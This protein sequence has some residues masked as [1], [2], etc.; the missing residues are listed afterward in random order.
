M[1]VNVPANL[2][3]VGELRKENIFVIDQQRATSQDIRPSED[4]NTQSNAP[5]ALD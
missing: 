2:P 3:A 5:E 1:P 4:C